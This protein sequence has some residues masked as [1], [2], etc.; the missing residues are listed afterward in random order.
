MVKRIKNKMDNWLR[1]LFD[2]IGYDVEIRTF[3]NLEEFAE[4]I[5][6][7]VE[8]EKYI[9]E[10]P[11]D[12]PECEL[13]KIII[14]KAKEKNDEKYH[15]D[16]YYRLL[17]KYSKKEDGKEFIIYRTVPWYIGKYHNK[18]GL[19]FLVRDDYRLFGEYNVDIQIIERQAKSAHLRF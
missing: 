13:S 4:Y 16:D 8:T 15:K 17:I 12:E 7:H 11:N 19:D 10:N 5:L 1:N 14:R 9:Y 2:E 18:S 6:N 3:H